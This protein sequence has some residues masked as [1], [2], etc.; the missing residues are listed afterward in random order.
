MIICSIS[1]SP[2]TWASVPLIFFRLAINSASPYRWTRPGRCRDGARRPEANSA[3][4]TTPRRSSRLAT[5]NASVAPRLWPNSA[6]GR[7]SHSPSSSTTRSASRSTEST[8]G[9]WRRSCRPGYWIETT[10]RPGD[11]ARETG[12]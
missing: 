7:S 12:K 4:G 6:S 5:S 1:S 3:T 10:S 8:P 2:S 9:S 11:S